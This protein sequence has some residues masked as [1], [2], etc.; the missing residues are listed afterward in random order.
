LRVLF[1][2]SGHGFGHATR[3]TALMNAL[4]SREPDVEMFICTRA[5]EWVFATSVTTR[6]AYAQVDLDAGVVERDLFHQDLPETLTRCRELAFRTPELLRREESW[7]REARIGVIVSD[8]PP[9]ASQVGQAAG[10]PVVA[11]SNFSWDD[12]YAPYACRHPGFSAVIDS[13]REGY[14]ATDLLLRL[15]FSTPMGA[16]PR[17]QEIPLIARRSAASP[18]QTRRDLGIRPD[19]SRP[20]LFLT[21]RM[22]SFPPGAVE[23]LAESGKYLLL[24]FLD[25]SF[26][27][28]KNLQ[29]LGKEWQPRFVDL[30]SASDIVLCKLGYG[31]VA[32][33]IAANTAIMHPPRYD[34]VEFEHLVE[35]MR[36]VLPAYPVPEEDFAAGELEEHIDAFLSQ[37]FTWGEM[38]VDGAG[39]AAEIILSMGRNLS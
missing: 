37:P 26:R 11:V 23:G 18:E 14:A 32:E 6:F 20:V 21:G 29:S 34:F 15:P 33:C 30:L 28:G 4:A 25:Q 31:I 3:M 7:V 39:T 13:M 2:I 38:P 5:P 9:L 10:V 22:Q 19:D 27:P 24:A 16:F 17:R 8:V 12:I 35:G 1:Y 36:G